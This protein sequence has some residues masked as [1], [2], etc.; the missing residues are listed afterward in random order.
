[1]TAEGYDTLVSALAELATTATYKRPATNQAG[2]SSNNNDGGRAGIGRG[3]K[4]K[5]WVSEDDTL[6]HRNYDNERGRGRTR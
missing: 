4:R 2:S 1:M 3:M 5:R 6:A